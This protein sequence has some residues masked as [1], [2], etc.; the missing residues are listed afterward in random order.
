MNH[1]P[2]LV[3]ERIVA[4]A[5][6]SSL[7]MLSCC[8]KWLWYCVSQQNSLWY[9]RYE[10]CYNLAD[11][12][13]IKWL[14]WY[15][16][17]VCASKL[18]VPQAETVINSAQLNNLHIEWFH[19]FCYRRAT[20][21]NWLR[22]TPYPIKDVVKEE[23]VKIQS[24]VLQRIAYY[25]IGMR[26]CFIVEQCQPI[27]EM[28]TKRFWRLR[29][30]FQDD[31]NYESYVEE[32]LMS[33]RFVVTISKHKNSAGFIV[34]PC[35]IS[36][37]PV[38]QVSSMRPRQFPCLCDNA[39]IRGRWMLINHL[40]PPGEEK[41]RSN[42]PTIT[43]IFDLANGQR[44]M[45]TITNHQGETFL[46]KATEEAATVFSR[47]LHHSDT[48]T[49]FKWNVWEF[50]NHHLGYGPRCLMQGEIRFN[51]F[52]DSVII[53][54]KLDDN[55]VLIENHLSLISNMARDA[56]A[57]EIRLAMIS[58]ECGLSNDCIKD[59]KPNWTRSDGLFGTVP[60]V[61]S[62]ASLLYLREDGRF[63]A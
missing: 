26:G 42:L 3:V 34:E 32:C 11:V 12:N 37:W 14:A 9:Q 25:R 13:E 51:K 29:K 60:L 20:D 55:R 6:S 22:D 52:K 17:T 27:G 62:T 59:A 8:S 53:V 48:T 63:T 1:I 41:D 16:K 10:Q 30:S 58:T 23:T 4:F 15:V 19:T 33:D 49:T 5:D 31:V 40:K 54:K 57:D 50:S 47:T 43:R 61:G 39:S 21:A 56:K 18:M 2:I 35:I 38:H 45:G 44:C 24:V 28:F 36:I 46:L 7:A